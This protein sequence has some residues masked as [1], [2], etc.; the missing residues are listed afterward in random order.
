[1]VSRYLYL[2]FALSRAFRLHVSCD[3]RGIGL[4]LGHM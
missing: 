1:M 2:G 4:S 3:F